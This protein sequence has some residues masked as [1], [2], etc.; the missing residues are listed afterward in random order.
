MGLRV[1]LKKITA[2]YEQRQNAL[3]ASRP[4]PGVKQ[5]CVF[6]TVAFF[7]PSTKIWRT[8]P[9]VPSPPFFLSDLKVEIQLN[10]ISLMGKMVLCPPTSKKWKWNWNIWGFTSHK[11]SLNLGKMHIW[12]QHDQDYSRKTRKLKS[13]VLKLDNKWKVWFQLITKDV[14]LRDARTHWKLYF[15]I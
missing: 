13:K 15:I 10:K 3:Q 2:K 9:P 8:L 11:F 6:L 5:S 1:W 12:E 7:F 4:K 14:T